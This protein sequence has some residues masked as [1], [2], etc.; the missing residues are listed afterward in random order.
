MGSPWKRHAIL[1][2]L[3]CATAALLRIQNQ[4]QNQRHARGQ[5]RVNNVRRMPGF[6]AF[7]GCTRQCSVALRDIFLFIEW[8]CR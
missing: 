5:P 3:S 8:S 6:N 4:R 1:A 2:T 7:C